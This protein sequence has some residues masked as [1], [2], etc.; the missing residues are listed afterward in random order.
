MRL[1][2]KLRVFIV[3]YRGQ[4]GIE[5]DLISPN[6]GWK[7][8]L[9]MI[10]GILCC[11]SGWCIHAISGER[12]RVDRIRLAVVWWPF[13]WGLVALSFS[14]FFRGE[15]PEWNMAY[16]LWNGK[17]NSGHPIV[18]SIPRWINMLNTQLLV[19]GPFGN[20]WME[21]SVEMVIVL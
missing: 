10:W 20:Q 15:F 3:F 8:E 1:R 9:G 7:G 17:W 13:F 16:K 21:W 11:N 19:S 12:N 6:L 14:V 18:N 5:H 2:M 4:M